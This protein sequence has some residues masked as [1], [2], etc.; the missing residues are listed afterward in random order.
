ML[1]DIIQ[2]LNSVELPASEPRDHVTVVG[3]EKARS[4]D[5]LPA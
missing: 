4:W 1:G 3:A 2:L 5:E